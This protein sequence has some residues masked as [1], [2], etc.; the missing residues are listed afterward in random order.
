MRFIL[1]IFTL[2]ST[3][4]I[5]YSQPEMVDVK[6]GNFMLGE[7][8]SGAGSLYDVAMRVELTDFRIGKYE[9]T[10]KE[11][12]NV[13]GDDPNLKN[14]VCFNDP[15]NPIT[16]IDFYTALIFCN[17]LSL[18]QGYGTSDLVYFKDSLFQFPYAKADYLVNGVAF[19]P[20]PVGPLVYC[21]DITDPEQIYVNKYPVYQDHSR[22]GYRLPTSSE[23]EYAAKGGHNIK[24]YIYAGSDKFEDVA[25]DN[26]NCNEKDKLPNSLGI[27]NMSGGVSELTSYSY[28]Y[29]ERN[30]AFCNLGRIDNFNIDYCYLN[31]YSPFDTNLIANIRGKTYR[32][33][34]VRG[35]SGVSNT[36][37]P[38][39]DYNV[40]TGL[41]VKVENG[42]RLAQ[43]NTDDRTCPIPALPEKTV[44]HNNG[45]P[46]DPSDDVFY[47]DIEVPLKYQGM[48]TWRATD[49]LQ[50][51]GKYDKKTRMGP[52]PI[53]SGG[54]EFVVHDSLSEGFV[55]QKFMALPPA[56]TCSDSCVL[57]LKKETIICDDNKTPLDSTDDVY[58]LDYTVSGL[59][60]TDKWKTLIDSGSYNLAYKFSANKTN[61]TTTLKDARNKCS[62]ELSIMGTPSCSDSCILDVNNLKINCLDN[63]TPLDASDDN[64]EVIM[65]IQGT[66]TTSRWKADTD[67]NPSGSYG[68][69]LDFGKYKISDGDKKILISDQAH[70]CS[71]E[72]LITAPATCSEA[73]DMTIVDKEINCQDNGTPYDPKDDTY[74]IRFKINSTNT[75]TFWTSSEGR[76]RYGEYVVLGPYKISDGDKNI[77][78]KDSIRNCRTT[79]AAQNVQPCSQSCS[80]TAKLVNITCNDAG[81]P[82]DGADDEFTAIVEVIANGGSTWIS[83]D[84][85]TKSG[86]Y[87]MN[88]LGSYL[89]DNGTRTIKFT[90]NNNPEC[91]ATITLTPPPSCS[92]KCELNAEVINTICKDNNTPSDSTDDE[93]IVIVNVTGKNTS[94]QVVIDGVVA[95]YNSNVTSKNYSISAGQKT[96]VIE[97]NL[98]PNCKID[99]VLNPPPTCSNKCAIQPSVVSTICND[100][101]TPSDSIDDEYDVVIKV[102][103]KNVSDSWRILGATSG[104]YDE[105]KGLGRYKISQGQKLFVVEDS[106]D[107]S[108]YEILEINPPLTCSYTC[109]LTSEVRGILCDDNGSP[110][111]SA[112]VNY[113]FEVR[114]TG[115]NTSGIYTDQTGDKEINKWHKYGPYR[116]K[117]GNTRLIFADKSNQNC[118]DTLDV[119]APKPCSGRCDITSI[120]D[121]IKCDNKGTDSDPSDD[122]FLAYVTIRGV[123]T[124]AEWKYQNKVGK[125][126]MSAPIASALIKNG[127]ITIQVQDSKDT[128]CNTNIFLKAPST[129][130]DQCELKLQSKDILPCNN[131]GTLS[132]GSD[133]FFE[134][135]YLVNGLNIDAQYRLIV[136]DV[137]RNINPY[138]KLDTIRLPANGKDQSIKVSDA[139]NVSCTISFIAN[140]SSCSNATGCTNIEKRET[141]TSCKPITWRERTVAQSGMIVDTVKL[142]NQCD[143]IFILDFTL[144]QAIEKSESLT[145]CDS[146][147]WR[148]KTY[149]TSGNYEITVPGI[150]GC[151]TLYKAKITIGSKLEKSESLTSCDS[152]SWRGKTYKTSGNYEVTMQGINGCDTIYKA[153]ITIGSKIEKS[154]SLTS[155]DS[156]L[157]RGKTYKTSGNYEVTVPG[158]NGC[159][160]I[161]KAKITIGSKLEKSESITSCD[162][163]SW[164]GKTY[165]TSGNYEATASGINGCDTLYKIKITIGSKIEKSESLTSCDSVLWRGKTYKTSGNYEATASGINGCD[166][167]Y[168]VKITI[169]SKIEKSESLTSCDSV[170][171]RGKTYKTS[172]S[173]EV[174]APGVNGCDTIYKAKITIGSKLEKSESL[175]SCDSI[176][177]RGKTY[178]TSGNYEVTMQGINGCDTIYKANLTINKSTQTEEKINLCKGDSIVINSIKIKSDSIITLISNTPSGCIEYKR[179]IISFSIETLTKD[180]ITI[181]HGDSIKIDGIWRRESN[182][183]TERYTFNKRCDSLVQTTL[184]VKPKAI[185]NKAIELCYGDSTS[186]NGSWFKKDTIITTQSVKDGCLSETKTTIKVKPQ[187]TKEESYQICPDDS[188]IINGSYYKSD[189]IIK[190]LKPGNGNCDTIITAKISK[191]PKPSQPKIELNCEEEKYIFTYEGLPSWIYQWSDNTT[192]QSK[193]ITSG[194]KISLRTTLPTSQKIC[195]VKFDYDLPLIPKVAEIPAFDDKISYSDTIGLIVKLDSTWQVEW[196]TDQKLNCDTCKSV[197]IKVQK[198]SD[199]EVKLTHTSGCIYTKT[200]TITKW[201]DSRLSFPNIICASCPTNNSWNLTLPEDHKLVELLILD[202]WGNSVGHYKN[203]N[204]VNWSPNREG[205]SGY[206]TGVYVYKIKYEDGAGRMHMRVGDFTVVR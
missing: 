80:M 63:G 130:S 58:T 44:C 67:K 77:A 103:G 143:S 147:T 68:T 148:G 99:L 30:K 50:S 88:N 172:G 152:I 167:L 198:D 144:L 170:L 116:I 162:S 113:S 61:P 125:Y 108:C 24:D 76:G 102:S 120:I 107:K 136:N 127:D 55:T 106:N 135:V 112:D 75:S 159:D 48:N 86:S 78:I 6:G 202:R 97:D 139:K 165:K 96:I 174:I 142:A 200:F 90:D 204:E 31:F 70:R 105:E 3:T 57:T 192:T 190:Y 15:Y 72:V 38:I 171:W 150:N 185:E 118:K 199:V 23:W 161:Y 92:N 195:E 42:I 193:E 133:D 21:R 122:T 194:G 22:K 89:V 91:T 25:R 60:T 178:K 128:T 32:T 39:T 175:T 110:T 111:D 29:Y 206:N 59:N 27:Y 85:I 184:I 166:T 154:E 8:K 187:L 119:V 45:T 183:Y 53:K 145:S 149:K 138:N 33:V 181:C 124:S 94:N 126:N 153:N 71:K 176:S 163:V 155:C 54:F 73:C 151:D 62:V 56:E 201:N 43:T 160:T 129:C 18:K 46:L 156:V 115:Q 169:G 189:Q 164:R 40:V 168:K 83:D 203:T 114:V 28:F 17:E 121:S 205:S 35:Y 16:S 179:M 146:V 49:P 117:D 66:N 191:I 47:F 11:F 196:L 52:Y 158:I 37:Y 188:I 177:W 173:Y 186:L 82:S 197:S 9:V 93:Y 69:K 98:D 81:T 41:N 79:L 84:S 182:I 100:N 51:K 1:F 26:L 19:D 140:Q 141:K 4:L 132:D 109:K 65:D 13:M 131:N 36:A 95:S 2:L 14:L 101:G 5:A 7:N 87:G 34:L 104:R 74:T 137:Q 180:T 20:I 10:Q 134:V 123:N 64:Y 157:W 12:E